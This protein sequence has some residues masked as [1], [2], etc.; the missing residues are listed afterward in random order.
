MPNLKIVYLVVDDFEVMRQ[1]TTRQLRNLGADKI[2][3]ATNG[4]EALRILRQEH[5]DLV[6]SDLNMPVMSGLELLKAI[7][8]D[9]HL[10]R[11]PFLMI[12]SEYDRQVIQAVIDAGVNSL[13]LKPYTPQRLAAHI[14]K[15]IAYQHQ[16]EEQFQAQA[17]AILQA[18]PVMNTSTSESASNFAPSVPSC[19]DVTL[20]KDS[21]PS[22]LIVDDLVANQLLLSR[23]FNNNYF[24]RT[25]D[26]GEGALSIC[27]SD[28]PPDLVLLD[29]MMP[30]MDGF[31]V[32]RRMREYPGS[33]NIPII[34]VSAMTDNATQLK[35]M[36]LGAVDFVSKPIDLKLLRLRVSNF[37]RYVE[38][39]K[40]LQT[41]YD[42]MLELSRTR[43]VVDQ[44][45]RHDLRGPLAGALGLV[46]AMASDDVSIINP[47]VHL[48][49]VEDTV[50]QVLNM[51]NLSAEIFKIETGRFQLQPQPIQIGDILQRIVQMASVTFSEKK[52]ALKAQTDAQTNGKPVHALGD[53][54]F[55]YSL[56]QN[57][58]KNACEAAPFQ[59]QVVVSLSN[60]DPLRI[61]IKNSGVVPAE[62]RP[63]FFEKFT[64]K[65]ISGSGLGTYS[66]KLLTE[67]Q[68]GKITLDI[69][70]DDNTTSLWVTLPRVL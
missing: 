61:L 40:Q 34:F 70:D 15:T 27:S 53:A 38:M 35:C 9:E 16:Q 43:D 13:L 20:P 68:G 69:S 56:F 22:I 36:S 52:L 37:M 46:Q 51:I 64:S 63:R 58:V 6:L 11:L 21:R 19:P 17:S 25:V 7:R 12:T 49:L 33:E 41:A 31:E 24:V 44:I 39:H 5:V 50:L 23:L 65:K 67:A 3:T 30:G 4:I 55:C 62:I 1:V 28:T 2:L 57:L 10:R 32:A 48:R 18:Q 59:S 45:T 14:Q 47:K 26:S 8:A 54:L 42:D 29:I 60:T 66:A